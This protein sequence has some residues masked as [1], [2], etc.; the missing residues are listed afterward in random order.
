MG[1]KMGRIEKGHHKNRRKDI[2]INHPY[3]CQC[4][5]CRRLRLKR[6]ARS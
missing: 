5:P 1:K 6:E 4:R 3:D 2:I